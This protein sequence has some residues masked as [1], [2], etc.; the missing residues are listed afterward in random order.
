MKKWIGYASLAVLLWLLVFGSFRKLY[1]QATTG[2]TKI[3]TSPV[4]TTT[5]TTGTLTDGVAVSFEVT[6][7]NSAGES[8]PSN[9]VS[10]VVPAT[11]THTATLTWT[12]SAGATSYNVYDQI[13]TI[14]NPPAAL[15]LVIN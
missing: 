15:N 5:F 11:G 4:T 2:F 8:G 6:A 1:A 13:V 7:V 10:G 9:I 12:A 14:P 3:N